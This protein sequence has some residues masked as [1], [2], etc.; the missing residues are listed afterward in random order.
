MFP[1]LGHC[2]SE[3]WQTLHGYNTRF[4]DQDL[5][6]RP[7]VCRKHKTV[8]CEFS[9]YTARSS[10]DFVWL[11]VTHNKKIVH[12]ISCVTGRELEP[13]FLQFY[14]AMRVMQRTA[15]AVLVI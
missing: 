8:N 1:D 2:L 9:I 14:N 11:R 13:F 3:I 7:Q 15:N 10:L 6:S 5:I 12:N 4:D